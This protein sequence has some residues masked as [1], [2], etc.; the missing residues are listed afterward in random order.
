VSREVQTAM[1]AVMCCIQ[2][3]LGTWWLARWWQVCE[4]YW[5]CSWL[6]WPVTSHSWSHV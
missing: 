1:I 3:L 4:L 6:H 5:W 2:W